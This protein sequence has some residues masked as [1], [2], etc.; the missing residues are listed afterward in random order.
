MNDFQ[1]TPSSIA[2]QSPTGLAALERQIQKDLELIAHPG[3]TWAPVKHTSAGEHVTDV[4]VVGAGQSGLGIGLGL[5]REYITNFL[6]ID[7]QDQGSEGPWVT[8]ARMDTLRTVKN[9]IGV[10]FDLPNLTFQ[11]W[12]EAQ[13]GEEGFDRLVRIPRDAWMDYLNWFRRV[14]DLPVQNKTKLV[15]IKP[16]GEFIRLSV[17]REDISESIVCRKVVLATGMMGSGGKQLPTDLVS[18]LPANRWA[19]T[20]DE[21][22]FSAL[23]GKR[24]GV[25][26]AGASAFDNA[27]TALEAGAATVDLCARRPELPRLN[28]VRALE[29]SGLLRFFAD[30][31]DEQR[32]RFMHR[33][34]QL[35]VPPPQHTY[36][37]AMD[38][39]GFGLHLGSPWQ[40]VRL[41][42]DGRIDVAT[43]QRRFSFDFLIFGTGFFLDITK[44]P[45]LASIINH[46]AL[47]RD[48][49]TPS[50]E[51]AS[52]VI[53]QQPYLGRSLEF[54]EKTP[55][56]APWLKNVIFFG[57]A[58]TPSL[59]PIS[60]GLN[61][62]RFGLWRVVGGLSRSLF[63]EDFEYHYENYMNYRTPEFHPRS[64]D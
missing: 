38:M 56:E 60:A 10:D 34:F 46:I 22:D 42:D 9:L 49:F 20:A 30:L 24:I 55:G 11:S 23:Q 36:D 15:D 57:I 8:Y 29:F 1:A 27:L 63:T 48:R 2:S 59:A 19:H 47:W 25:L 53:G 43:P 37:R 12:Y 17:E 62:L 51:L 44:R 5:K 64:V 58:G 13:F 54:L 50:P 45:E 16:E 3:R 4:V 39:P 31:P 6:I 14:I 61:G 40:E 52:D 28:F 41:L 18:G 7:E 33:V 21:I 35:Q 32:W 26:G